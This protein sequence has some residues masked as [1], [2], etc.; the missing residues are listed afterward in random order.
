MPLN[1]TQEHSAFLQQTILRENTKHF[2]RMIINTALSQES[3]QLLP[4]YAH[5]SWLTTSQIELL[6]TVATV[7]RLFLVECV[8]ACES[9]WYV[10][11]CQSNRIILSEYSYYF[12]YI[13]TYLSL[14]SN[15]GSN[16]STLPWYNRMS[17]SW[18][19][20]FVSPVLRYTRTRTHTQ[21]E[22]ERKNNNN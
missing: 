18:N 12:L 9:V 10:C 19:T 6:A 3:Q 20:G 22:M 14:R 1:T 2:L 7:V 15:S 8:C 4:Q 21:R 16:L 5:S 13:H 17:S 11:V